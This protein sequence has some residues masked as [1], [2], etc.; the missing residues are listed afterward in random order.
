MSHWPMYKS[1]TKPV[2]PGSY[3][4]FFDFIPLVAPDGGR[5]VVDKFFLVITG[6]ITVA[7]AL[8]DG[9]DVVRLAQLISVEKRDARQ[10]WTLSGY[11]SRLASIKYNGIEEHQEHGNVA[12][13]AAQAVNLRLLIPMRK[14]FTRRPNDFALPADAFKKIAVT[15]AALASAQTGTT[16]LSA[17]SLNAYILA[18]WHSEQKVEFKVDDIVKSVDSNSATQARTALSGVLHDLDVC[19]EDTTAGGALVSAITDARIEDLGTPTLTFGDLQHSYSVKRQ[20]TPSGPVTPATERF[21]DPVRSSQL[22]PVLTSDN[23][24]SPW[25]GRIVD[26]LKLDVGTGLAGFAIITREVVDK[27]QADYQATMA[28]YNISPD[29]LKFA[30]GDTPNNAVDTRPITSVS[31]RQQLVGTWI[32]PLKKAV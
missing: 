23:V 26:S 5:V 13:G 10:R 25:D 15:W 2:T 31:K 4:E 28:R 19:K 30:V 27:S 8:W 7:T 14:R 22:M 32:G 29:D 1:D 17:N 24:T 21:L 20:I 3:T 9:R 12:I 18:E 11:K 6:T 16:V